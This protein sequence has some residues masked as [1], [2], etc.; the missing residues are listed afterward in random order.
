MTGVINERENDKIN[1]VEIAIA[2]RRHVPLRF[3]SI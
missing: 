2:R 1:G 3:A